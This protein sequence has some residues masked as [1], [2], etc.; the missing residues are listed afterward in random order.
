MA[1]P[2]DSKKRRNGIVGTIALIVLLVSVA[3]LSGVT[4]FNYMGHSASKTTQ[5]AINASVDN[6]INQMNVALNIK[7]LNPDGKVAANYSYPHDIITNQFIKFL[8]GMWGYNGNGA[9]CPSANNVGSGT[10]VSMC[11]GTGQAY[12]PFIS[13]Y[14]GSVNTAYVTNDGGYIGI[15]TGTTTVARA[16]Y[17]L[18]TQVGSWAP[19]T[20]PTISGNSVTVVASITLTSPATISEAGFAEQLG[21]CYQASCPLG[22]TTYMFLFFHDTFAGFAVGT[23]QTVQIQYTLNL[24]SGSNQNLVAWLAS[25]MQYVSTSSTFF[26]IGAMVDS[27]GTTHVT[28]SLAWWVQDTSSGS[29]SFVSD[30]AMPSIEVGTSNTAPATTDYQ[31]NAQVGSA[32]AIVTET[33]DLTNS[34]FLDQGPIP[35]SSSYT[36]QEIGFFYN[37]ESNEVIY[38]QGSLHFLLFHN[39]IAAV[40][41]PSGN[42]ITAQFTVGF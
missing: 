39:T 24:P 22:G 23:D 32:A 6:L 1:T 30:P 14:Y 19:V 9:A 36:I 20:T 17:K 34:L 25:S 13:A 2:R 28:G 18:Q 4:A 21:A 37:G 27:T 33:T 15:G 11:G 42:A 12:S 31:L 38:N 35:L 29:S 26:N 8:A 7:V 10:S 41:I 5:T 3:A 40:A 16:D